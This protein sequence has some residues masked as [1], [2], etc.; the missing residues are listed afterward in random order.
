MKRIVLIIGLPGS[1]K[2]SIAKGIAKKYKDA[3][4]FSTEE[5]RSE[6]FSI[7]CETADCDFTEE[8]QIKTYNKMAELVRKS[9]VSKELVIC[10]GV[11]RS[12]EQRLLFENIAKE[13][14]AQ[15]F[16][17]YICCDDTIERKRLVERKKNN[18]ISPSGVKT[19]EIIK[20]KYEYPSLEDNYTIIDNSGDLEQS[21]VSV[22]SVLEKGH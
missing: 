13:E 10:E 5:I 21:L 9:I 8:Q 14:E 7:S 16:K 19:Y 12:N 1:G 15:L 20:K 4:Y 3:P 22:I 17:F 6:L 2:T 11:F 18:T